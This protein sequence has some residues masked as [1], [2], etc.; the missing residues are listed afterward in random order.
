MI[1][2]TIA[3][4]REELLTRAEEYDFIGECYTVHNVG[5]L[6]SIAYSLATTGQFLFKFSTCMQ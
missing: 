1:G 4:M 5:S 6:I 3:D 2:E